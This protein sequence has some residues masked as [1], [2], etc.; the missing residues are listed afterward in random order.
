MLIRTILDLERLA[1]ES[2][3]HNRLVP[4]ARA[5]ALSQKQPRGEAC[6]S[7]DLASPRMHHPGSGESNDASRSRGAAHKA[8][9]IHPSPLRECFSAPSEVGEGKEDPSEHVA[10]QAPLF[11]GGGKR[12]GGPAPVATK[13][14]LNFSSHSKRKKIKKT[15]TSCVLYNV[16]CVRLGNERQCQVCNTL[17]RKCV[18]PCRKPKQHNLDLDTLLSEIAQLEAKIT[19]LLESERKARESRKLSSKSN[20]EQALVDRT[21]RA[22]SSRDSRKTS[23][24]R[25][26]VMIDI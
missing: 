8:I 22:L 11:V 9:P 3:D 7:P 17:R 20:G 6:T 4:S 18:L 21:R 15:C 10:K 2:D 26:V 5:S 14:K 25:S 23:K 19:R 13:C 24:G 1:I 16:R 12:E